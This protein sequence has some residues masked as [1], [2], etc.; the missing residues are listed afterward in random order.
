[1]AV[2]RSIKCKFGTAWSKL[3]KGKWII[4]SCCDVYGKKGKW[5]TSDHCREVREWETEEEF[6]ENGIK[7]DIVVATMTDEVLISSD[8]DEMVTVRGS[9]IKGDGFTIQLVDIR[10]A[11]DLV[12]RLEA[13]TRVRKLSVRKG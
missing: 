1:M 13:K 3:L 11:T 4:I 7:W 12:D 8:A 9:T 2:K 6:R 10:P 5:I